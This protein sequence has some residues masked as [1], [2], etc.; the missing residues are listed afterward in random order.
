MTTTSWK[1]VAN[2]DDCLCG[3]TTT[4]ALQSQLT[5]TMLRESQ[6]VKK[7]CIWGIKQKPRGDDGLVETQLREKVV[8][9][10]PSM[11]DDHWVQA[12]PPPS[13]PRTR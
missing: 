7:R 6:I 3:L 10:D 13:R 9:R 5:P 2:D 11:I 4:E 1:V 12:L 8:D